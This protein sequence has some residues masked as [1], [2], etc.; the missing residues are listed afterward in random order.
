MLL[1]YAR[2]PGGLT[3]EAN[4]KVGNQFTS[5]G[6]EVV[7]ISL[8]FT[9]TYYCSCHKLSCQCRGRSY[10]K[11][12]VCEDGLHSFQEKLICIV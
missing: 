7:S 10:G 9:P 1:L 2:F 4:R 3:M 6:L 11:T 8:V 12:I 5:K